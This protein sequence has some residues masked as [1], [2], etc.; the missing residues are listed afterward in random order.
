MLECLSMFKKF[1][2]LAVA[3]LTVYLACNAQSQE[4][5]HKS[6]GKQPA[7]AAPALTQQKSQS[8]EFRPT[9]TGEQK[10]SK[11][12][13]VDI[14]DL[15][16][17]DVYD[18]ASIW[19]NAGLA[20]IGAG[21]IVVAICTLRKIERQTVATEMAASA[22]HKSADVAAN[23]ERAWVITSQASFEPLYSDLAMQ[24][25]PDRSLVLISMLN[26]GR[27]PAEMESTYCLCFMLPN[28]LRLPEEPS[29]EGFEEFAALTAIPGEIIPIGETRHIFSYIRHAELISEAEM[30]DLRN[31]RTVLYCYGR[32]EYKDLLG[33]LRVTQFRYYYYFRTQKGDQRLPGMYR[34]NNR[35]YN[36]TT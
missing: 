21:G 12:T 20:L 32:F 30:N 22:A 31:G 29:Y 24:G 9:F 25:A 17:K 15:P 34:I 27:S 23:A 33:G 3:L 2:F 5:R 13:Q 4:T 11:S 6:N 10:G 14:V 7:I 8:S 26:S 16:A 1:T 18:K 19:I 28:E 35:A 36:F